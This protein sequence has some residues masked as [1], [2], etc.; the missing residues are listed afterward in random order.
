MPTATKAPAGTLEGMRHPRSVL[1][2]RAAL[3]LAAT[4]ALATGCSG[5]VRGLRAAV[6]DDPG[7]IEVSVTENHGDDDWVWTKITKDVQVTMEA[8]ATADEIMAVF[9]AYDGPIEDGAVVGVEVI[10]AGDKNAVLASGEGVHVTRA[11]VDDLVAAEA[12]D[13]VLEYRREAYPTLP[14][15]YLDIADADFDAVAATADRY[16]GSDDLESVTVRSGAFVLVRDEINDDLRV[17]SARERLVRRVADRFSV[18]GAVVTGRGP[19]KLRVAS[20]DVDPVRRL[21]SRN[22]E[23]SLVRKVVLAPR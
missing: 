13:G 1:R 2:A 14:S 15:V 7:V 8:D 16:R 12:D 17:T 10:L 6:A 23:A 11:A 3:V 21:V 18:L 20:A 9:D 5:S 22:P 4:L 19:L